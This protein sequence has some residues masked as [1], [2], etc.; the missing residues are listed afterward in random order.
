MA[1]MQV[2]PDSGRRVFGSSTRSERGAVL[3]EFATIMPVLM[4][5]TIG[6]FQTG[7]I[8]FQQQALHS[9]AREGAREAA[10][11]DSTTADIDL[12]VND[13]LV[14]VNFANAPSVV[15]TPAVTQPCLD[16]PGEAVTV[17]LNTSAT[18]DI[19]F[20]A[21]QTLSLNSQ[22]TFRCE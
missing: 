10:I 1:R 4:M 13:A 20:L 5:I 12:A 17:N 11:P 7:L 6:I 19:P 2:Q 16:R 14:G 3:I 18:L 21:G 9:A 22:A 15:V 8:L